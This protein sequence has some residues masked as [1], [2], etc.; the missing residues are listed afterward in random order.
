[1]LRCS[2]SLAASL[3]LFLS[4]SPFFFLFFFFF[5]STR[6]RD[7]PLQTFLAQDHNVPSHVIQPAISSLSI[8][9][10]LVRLSIS[11][12]T[13]FPSVLSP[14]T[15][16]DKGLSF[17]PGQLAFCVFVL[18]ETRLFLSL[19]SFLLFAKKVSRGPRAPA[20]RQGACLSLMRDVMVVGGKGPCGE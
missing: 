18:Y 7:A 17:L 19:Y 12:R 11:A 20:L 13:L 2:L 14:L 15:K 5:A 9:L 4:L 8:P 3:S 6:W 16:A 1:M 10:F